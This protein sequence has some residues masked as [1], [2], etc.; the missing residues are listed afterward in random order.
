MYL[1]KVL[2][3]GQVLHGEQYVELFKPLPT[4][5]TWKSRGSVVDIIDKGSGA[6][7]IINGNRQIL[8]G[9]IF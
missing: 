8:I 2:I 6:V 4:A 1:N 9:A 3:V 5:G 7:L